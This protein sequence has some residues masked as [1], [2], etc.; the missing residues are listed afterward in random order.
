MLGAAIG[1]CYRTIRSLWDQKTGQLFDPPRKRNVYGLEMGAAWTRDVESSAAEMAFGQAI[2]AYWSGQQGQ[3]FMD[4]T[5][6]QV[7]HSIEESNCLIIHDEGEGDNWEHKFGFVTGE[8]GIYKI[9]GW[10]YGKN[11]PELGRYR[12]DVRYP[13]W[14]IPKDKLYWDWE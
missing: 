9:W 10:C 5:G 7:R 2:G 12:D 11:A 4:V 13:A 8:V 3:S 14:F 1:G 6:Y